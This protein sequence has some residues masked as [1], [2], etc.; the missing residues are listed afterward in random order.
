MGIFEARRGQHNNH[1]NM[2]IT[3]NTNGY[4]AK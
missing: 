3:L 1:G 2:L 4:R